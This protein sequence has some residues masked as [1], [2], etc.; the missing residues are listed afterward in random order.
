MCRTILAPNV[1]AKTCRDFSFGFIWPNYILLVFH[2]VVQVFQT[3][4][5]CGSTCFFSP[6]EFCA[7]CMNRG[8]CHWMHYLLFSWEK[9]YLWFPGLSEA[10]WQFPLALDYSFV[11][12]I[13]KYEGHVGETNISS[14]ISR[15][16]CG[17]CSY[18]HKNRLYC[19]SCGVVILT[20]LPHLT[21][22]Y[23]V[24]GNTVCTLALASSYSKELLRQPQNNVLS[25][26]LT[27]LSG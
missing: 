2:W 1:S 26:H 21:G 27:V 6:G 9:L 15:K 5:L 7:V 16:S 12:S 13:R 4:L 20:K 3:I 19:F 10:L 8:H 25:A 18:S 24:S 11:C 22:K 17:G 23:W 14:F